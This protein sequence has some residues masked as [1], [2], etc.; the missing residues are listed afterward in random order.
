MEQAI[1]RDNVV[2]NGLVFIVDCSGADLGF[3]L[4]T[5]HF[6]PPLPLPPSCFSLP[7]PSPHP[8]LFSFLLPPD[9]RTFMRVSA[10]CMYHV[11]V[12]C[13]LH[14]HVS[15]CMYQFGCYVCY[16][17]MYHVACI[18]SDIMFATRACIMLHVS[19]RV[20]CLLHELATHSGIV[21]VGCVREPLIKD[22]TNEPPIKDPADPQSS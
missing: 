7:P 18:S 2:A 4:P 8:P 6:A 1:R 11:R 12:L 21:A 10:I 20:L 14:E 19:V 15:C 22:P 16:T 9:A 3:P 17:S 5:L 13:L